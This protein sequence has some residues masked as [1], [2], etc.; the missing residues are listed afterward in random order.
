MTKGQDSP[1]AAILAQAWELDRQAMEA[2]TPDQR[3]LL[4]NSKKARSDGLG[5]ARK[6]IRDYGWQPDLIR[7]ANE[8]YWAVVNTSSGWARKEASKHARR[9]DIDFDDALSMVRLGMFRAAFSF[10]PS[11]GFHFVTHC[12]HWVR[13]TVD[14][15]R[16]DDMDVTYPR[17]DAHRSS[18]FP[19]AV[20]LD[21]PL[22]ENGMTMLDLLPAP[23]DTE[24]ATEQKE[25]LVELYRQIQ[26]LPDGVREA[27]QAHLAGQ[28]MVEHAREIG[29]SR[30][31]A[32]DRLNRGI[33]L[34][35][36]RMTVDTEPKVY[37][38]GHPLYA[39]PKPGICNYYGCVL[40]GTRRSFCEKHYNRIR[41][42]RTFEAMGFPS[43]FTPKPKAEAKT[44]AMAEAKTE[45]PSP[46]RKL[47]ADT[48]LTREDIQER[49][50]CLALADDIKA[51][52]GLPSIQIGSK[53]YAMNP[54]L[55]IALS[56]LA[57]ILEARATEVKQ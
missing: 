41:D 40:P 53:T 44:E 26:K 3:K 48:T 27:V 23:D 47:K 55:A 39:H 10:D 4:L 6:A 13:S 34:L 24:G 51:C 32:T 45:A 7:K 9:L 5:Y 11:L 38:E 28:S 33:E 54:I 17:H 18:R 37:K 19:R 16:V 20:R 31:T 8:L 36:S 1:V 52:I 56:D 2:C 21:A 57:K 35:K 15:Q 22:T 25:H 46:K 43:R 12:K 50:M 42:A 30:A 29:F 14:R 49:A